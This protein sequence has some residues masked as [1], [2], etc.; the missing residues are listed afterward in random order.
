MFI[1]LI[2]FDLGGLKPQGTA[3][4]VET[5]TKWEII[6]DNLFTGLQGV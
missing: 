4:T 6:F 5:L 1:S 3:A 2:F